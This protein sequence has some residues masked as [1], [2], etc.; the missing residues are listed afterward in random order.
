VTDVIDLD[1]LSPIA[2]PMVEGVLAWAATQPP[3]LTRQ[4]S[5]AAQ[6]ISISKQIDLEKARELDAIPDGR[7][8]KITTKSIVRR[9]VHNIIATYPADGTVVA[10]PAVPK[11]KRKRR[12]LAPPPPSQT[13]PL[14]AAN[15]RRKEEAR[16][17][18]GETESVS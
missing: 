8:T 16:E 15:A 4:E 14:H 13:A 7:Q 18:R 11:A 2:R 9:M 6:R 1:T 17:R 3:F 5:A 12:R 10:R